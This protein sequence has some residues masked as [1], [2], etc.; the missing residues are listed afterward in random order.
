MRS[1]RRLQQRGFTLI[2]TL[3]AMSILTVVVVSTVGV[4]FVGQSSVRSITDWSDQT[5]QLR[6]AMK[7]MADDLSQSKWT[8]NPS[9]QNE[10]TALVWQ[11][12]VDRGN[13]SAFDWTV[14]SAE[15]PGDLVEWVDLSI[16]YTIEGDSLIRLVS[17]PSGTYSQR[18]VVTNLLSGSYISVDSAR[19]LVRIH[20]RK[21]AAGVTRV[22]EAHA[23]FFVR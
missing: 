21:Q 20:L 4:L 23:E 2:E 7:Q 9:A 22:A 14:P 16:R 6:L 12:V 3:I 1:E 19:H 13:Y 15:W 10:I 17:D 8:A 18:V 5:Q 11:P